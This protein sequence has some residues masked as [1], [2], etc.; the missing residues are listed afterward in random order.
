MYKRKFVKIII[1]LCLMLM[2]LSSALFFAPVISNSTTYSFG[3]GFSGDDSA[4]PGDMITI[5]VDVNNITASGGLLSYNY[6]FNYNSAV[7]ELENCYFVNKPSSLINISGGNYSAPGTDSSSM[8]GWNLYV[9]QPSDNSNLFNV[10]A[11]NELNYQ[12][13]STEGMLKIA[14]NFTVKSPITVNETTLYIN[15][16]ASLSGTDTSL[17][18]VLGQ[19][20]SMIVTLS[21]APLLGDVN[22]D[23]NVDPLDLTFMKRFFACWDTYTTINVSAADLNKDGTVNPIDSTILARHF[24]NWEGYLV[25]E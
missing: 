18:N 2:A 12:G 22:L 25:L 7:L 19:G 6:A 11:V 3:V 8:N 14:Y 9:N 17:N 15:T 20:S 23:G 21:D 24:A 1:F 10:F 5:Y 4:G 13:I 16:A